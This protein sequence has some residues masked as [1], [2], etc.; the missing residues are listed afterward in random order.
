M[1]GSAAALNAYLVSQHV[2]EAPADTEKRAAVLLDLTVLVRAWIAGVGASKAAQDGGAG[3]KVQTF[4]SYRLGVHGPGSDVDMLCVAP[5]CVTRDDF[6]TLLPAVLA[7]SAQLT[8][9]QAVPGAFVPIL[10]LEFGGI[11]VDLIF[12]QMQLASVPAD[13]DLQDNRLLRNL[14]EVSVRSLNGARTTDVILRLVPHMESYRS[15]LVAVKHWSKARGISSNA[16]GYLGGINLAIIMAR[17]CQLYPLI[18]DAAVLVHKFFYVLTKWPFP[19][20]IMLC[21]VVDVGLGLR[22]WSPRLYE[23]D[24]YDVMPLLTPAY[25]STNSAFSTT[26]SA[27]ALLKKEWARGLRVCDDVLGASGTSGTSG[28]SG[29]SS[30]ADLCAPYEFFAEFSHFLQITFSA[31]TMAAFLTWKGYVCAK[32]R[33]FVQKLEQVPCVT[34]RGWSACFPLSTTSACCF[35]GLRF[36]FPAAPA[37]PVNISAPVAAFKSFM[38]GWAEHKLDQALDV[39]HVKRAQLPAFVI[40]VGGGGS[41]SRDEKKRKRP[42]NI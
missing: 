2:F 6:F 23:R 34:C 12:A 1:D 30:W 39:V 21:P 22:Q 36:T 42:P 31:D 7:R 24:G 37:A 14:D 41:S 38:L 8:E 26:A 10:K 4:G 18:S 28:A 17:V 19:K 27:L 20:P 9:L 40:P 25:P 15:A 5:A 35:V 11:A 13:L 16:L 32:L 3:G 29:T 33:A